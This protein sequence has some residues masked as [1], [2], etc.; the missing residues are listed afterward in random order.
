M[1]YLNW[2]LLFCSYKR[3]GKACV[4][5]LRSTHEN[6]RQ[7]IDAIPEDFLFRDSQPKHSCSQGR[8]EYYISVFFP[9][10]NEFFQD[11]ESILKERYL[12]LL[13]AVLILLRASRN[14]V[15]QWKKCYIYIY[16]YIEYIVFLPV[17]YF[18]AGV[19]VQRF[20][21]MLSKLTEYCFMVLKKR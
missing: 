19:A 14:G 3:E 10:R 16:I 1:L 9:S 21:L 11:W 7:E 18:L 12:N 20:L 2:L 8:C 4:E 15:L 6:T 17:K 5:Q 13:S